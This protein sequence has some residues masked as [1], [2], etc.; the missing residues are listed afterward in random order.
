MLIFYPRPA[1]ILLVSLLVTFAWAETVG[2]CYASTV[3]CTGTSQM[4]NVTLSKSE[5]GR[6]RL[7]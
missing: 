3:V 6:A 4:V 5:S 7:T 1:T 2:H